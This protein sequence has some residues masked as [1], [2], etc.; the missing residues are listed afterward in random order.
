MPKKEMVSLEHLTEGINI[1][2][3]YISFF[4]MRFIAG[5]Q[6]RAAAIAGVVTQFV[7]GSMG[8]LTYKAFYEVNPDAFPMTFQALST[9]IWLQQS[10]LALFMIWFLENDIFQTI[11]D[12]GIAYEL[13]RPTDL[14]F[15]WFFRSMATR[16]SKTVLRCMPILIVAAFLPS[17]YGMRL[18][19]N[20]NAGLWFAITVG[21]GFL[22]VVAFCMLIYIS[23]FYTF[24]PM[25]VRL[26]AIS[27]V[28]FFAGTII[29][30]PF[31]PDRIRQ[32]VELL[33]FASMQNIPLRIYSGDIAGVD[34]YWK[35]GLQLFW[36]FV[37]IWIGKRIT[38]TAL[39][40][41]VVQGG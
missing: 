25:G 2:K 1:Y 19:V 14:Y 18:P 29:P 33:P 27:V 15:M 31:L 36:V 13:C 23:T 3:K 9:Y 34:I 38:A 35:A 32:V 17:P 20:L 8:I 26:V 28:E 21:L 22:V 39:K 4:R 16:L 30:L 10:L 12:G 5:L 40:R 24:S 7:W 41:V 11:T 37:L 6:Y